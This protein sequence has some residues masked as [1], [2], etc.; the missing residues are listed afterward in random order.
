LN[1]VEQSRKI[2][3]NINFD[4]LSDC[5][6]L[7]GI[8]W[9][10]RQFQKDPSFFRVMD[11]FLSLC[12]EFGAR[13]TIFVIGRDLENGYHAEAVAKWHAMGHEIA[14]HSY[15]HRHDLGRLGYDQVHEEIERTDEIVK[16]ATGYSP[17]GFTSPGWH[18]SSNIT[19]VL[20][21]MGYMYDAS[22]GPTW[23]FQVAQTVLWLKSPR[24]RNMVS[25]LRSDWIGNFTGNRFPYFPADENYLR[26]DDG[27][28]RAPVMIPL[29]TLP[30]SR[31]GLW[32]TLSFSLPEFFYMGMLNGCMRNLN[33]FYYLIHPVDL[34]DSETD[35]VGFPSELRK[36]HRMCVPILE[37]ERK[38]RR[39]FEILARGGA[40]ATM[41]EIAQESFLLKSVTHPN[42]VLI[43]A[44]KD[45]GFSGS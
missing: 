17:R 29:P 24:A 11:R 10:E 9:P 43:D 26:E 2:A 33:S 18:S 36:I 40:F 42:L 15:T 6:K 12:S 23:L 3:L 8:P 1:P 22:L 21:K 19:R 30:W 32:H 41:S 4:S 39:S 38:L 31:L 45:M 34:F 14:N 35:L 5:M 25:F 27:V 13:L 44:P 37:K 7:L 16:K 20:R 28:S